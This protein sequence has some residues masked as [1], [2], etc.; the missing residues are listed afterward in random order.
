MATNEA[1]N[2][3]QSGFLGK[4]LDLIERGG[5]KLPDPAL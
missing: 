1:E 3:Q 5:N 2:K 4:A